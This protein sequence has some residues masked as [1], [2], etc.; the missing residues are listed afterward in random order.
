[1]ET[2]L[3]KEEE[4]K[5]KREEAERKDKE[6]L[7]KITEIDSAFKIVKSKKVGLLENFT[8]SLKSILSLWKKKSKNEK[9]LENI[10]LTTASM[11]ELAL[12]EKDLSNFADQLTC[13]ETSEIVKFFYITYDRFSKKLNCLTIKPAK[14]FQI[15]QNILTKEG[16]GVVS[17]ALFSIQK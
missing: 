7:D 9:I 16:V 14:I 3:S 11:V 17:R 10:Y 13:E 1:M 12:S 2:R 8:N 6:L 4:K 5:Q 15:H